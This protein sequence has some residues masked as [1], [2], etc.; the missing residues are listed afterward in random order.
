MDNTLRERRTAVDWASE[1]QVVDIAEKISYFGGL[2]EILDADLAALNLS[3]VQR[4]WR[5]N[6]VVGTLRFGFAGADSAVAT[7]VGQVE[8]TVLAVCQRCLEP[9]SLALRVEPR[10][11][12]LAQDESADDRVEKL[13]EYEVWE[14]DEEQL[15]PAELLEELLIMALPFAAKHDKAEECAALATASI[16]VVAERREEMKKPFA[17]LRSQMTQNEKD[18]TN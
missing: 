6:E 1:L 4:E 15:R 14:L 3:A 17:A 2:V 16:S 8:V 11:L 5:D 9:F 13:A 7:L 10:L 12:L 18:P